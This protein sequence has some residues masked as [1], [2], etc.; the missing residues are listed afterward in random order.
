MLLNGNNKVTSSLQPA[1]RKGFLFSHLLFFALKL[2]RKKMLRI[3][4]GKKKD[5]CESR[6]PRAKGYLNQ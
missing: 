4:Q 2:L 3:A 6:A 5:L 1:L